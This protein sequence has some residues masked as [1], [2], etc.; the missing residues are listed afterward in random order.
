MAQRELTG[1]QRT[2]MLTTERAN[3]VMWNM[4]QRAEEDTDSRW[5][6]DEAAGGEE[7]APTSDM[8]YS[9][10]ND[11]TSGIPQLRDRLRGEINRCLREEQ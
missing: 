8:E 7:E 6:V 11:Q 2:H 1:E 3:F 10:E 4:R 9:A 5:A